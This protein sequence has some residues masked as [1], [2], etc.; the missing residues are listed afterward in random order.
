MTTPQTPT[1]PAPF[2]RSALDAI[3]AEIDRVLAAAKA[4]RAAATDQA[5]RGLNP[6]DFDWTTEAERAELHELQLAAVPLRQ[7]WRAGAAERF[8]I[9]RA[10]RR[11][12]L[13]VQS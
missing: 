10:A 7:A 1:R 6:T 8:A 9:K 12:A 3:E 5:I 2:D 11:A 13:E 4:R